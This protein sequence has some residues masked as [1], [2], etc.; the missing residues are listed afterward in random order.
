MTNKV[1]PQTH[2]NK[3]KINNEFSKLEKFLTHSYSL[4]SHSFEDYVH[5]VRPKKRLYIILMIKFFGGFLSS[6]RCISAMT[7]GSPLVRSIMS[8]ANHIMGNRYII[9]LIMTS[10][11]LGMC[12]WVGGFTIL[13]DMKMKL[14]AIDHLIIMRNQLTSGAMKSEFRNNFLRRLYFTNKYISWPL[15]I[16]LMTNATLVF[17]LPPIGAYF[18][19][20]SIYSMPS[21][22]FWT[23]STIVLCY[24]FYASLF[25]MFIL[26][27]LCSTYLRYQ[28]KQVN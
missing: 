6:V 28:F 14:I 18:Q 9:S 5:G 11:G 21:I 23:I 8:E 10:G 27:Y 13:M 7:M 16:F 24:D 19:P 17:S 15:V 26:I 1:I 3:E 12:L 25:T 4:V 22:I 20:G 2:P